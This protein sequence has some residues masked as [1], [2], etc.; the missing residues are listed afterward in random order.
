MF[1]CRAVG[2]DIDPRRVKQSRHNLK[3]RPGGRPGHG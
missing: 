2:F 1:N 3:K